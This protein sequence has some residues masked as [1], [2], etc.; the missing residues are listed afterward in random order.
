[1]EIRQ[2]IMKGLNSE[3]FDKKNEL[4]RCLD[5]CDK[6]ERK[7]SRI[8]ANTR[9]KRRKAQAQ[10]TLHDCFEQAAPKK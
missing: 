4:S 1:M 8:Q 7:F 9:A 3:D 2:H 10:L 6:L 5:A